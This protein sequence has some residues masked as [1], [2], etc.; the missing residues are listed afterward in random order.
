MVGAQAWRWTVLAG[1]VLVGGCADPTEILNPEFVDNL[2]R[3]S[4]NVASLPG[5][6]PGLA[7]FVENQTTRWI[8]AAVSYRDGDG[9]ARSFTQVVG[10]G[11]RTGQ[12]LVCQIQEITLGNVSDLDAVGAVVYLSDPATGSLADSPFVEVEP[13]GL[14]L[15]S[16][17][18]Y[19][20]GDGVDFIVRPSSNTASGYQTYAR[21]RTN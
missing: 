15:R 21:L 3:G 8:S 2:G 11:E 9:N 7:V 4:G 19:E 18:N 17:V 16:G 1:L 5:D 6:A 10:P 13:F 12:M 20:C 14:L